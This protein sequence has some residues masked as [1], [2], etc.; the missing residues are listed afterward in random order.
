MPRLFTRPPALTGS[1][2]ARRPARAHSHRNHTMTETT[3]E[4]RGRS[5]RLRSCSA[6]ILTGWLAGCSGGAGDAVPPTDAAAEN[7]SN[8]AAAAVESAGDVSDRQSAMSRPAAAADN[9]NDSESPTEFRPLNMS[10][11]DGTAGTE[12]AA[13]DASSGREQQ[14][15]P[16]DVIDRLRPLQILLGNWRG[17]TRREYDGFKAVDNHE[18]VWDL[19][20]EPAR[21]ALTLAS[22]KSPYLRDARL[23]WDGRN[24]FTL[25][26]T[27]SDDVLRE[28]TGDF[29]EAVAEKVG[30]DEK[31]HRTFRLRL[32]Q[33]DDSV[34]L[35][36]D[37]FRWQLEI[38]QQENNRYLLEVSR[39]RGTGRL[40][41]LDTV[42]T[43]REGTSFA[44]SDTDY[45]EKTCIISQGLGT[46]SVSFRGQTYW[47][48][49]SGCKAAFD[50]D[51][52]KWIARAQAQQN[53][54]DG[55][56]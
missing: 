7:S 47:V 33:T 42:S 29:S 16:D 26:G 8:S 5:L 37:G 44:I 18:W 4:S 41:R 10:A 53:K 32:V 24:Q 34:Q 38:A 43:Q 20:T 50:E 52:E 31:L 12:N 46:I 39:V 21:P 55:T 30:D 51:P 1:G 40:Q 25:I 14:T 27:D 15:D 3:P 9:R 22:D 36:G 54:S 28:F 35:V 13:A 6:W 56:D 49:C 45:G 23:T 19:T 48:C 11:L 17:T 2:D